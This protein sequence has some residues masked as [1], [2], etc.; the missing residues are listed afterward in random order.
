[1]AFLQMMAGCPDWLVL[2]CAVD[3]GWP[4]RLLDHAA[5][6]PAGHVAHSV[7]PGGQGSAAGAVD[8][9]VQPDHGQHRHHQLCARPHPADCAV[10]GHRR[11]ALD[12]L[13]HRGQGM[14]ISVWCAGE[15]CLCRGHGS[16][17]AALCSL[18]TR[19]AASVVH[20]LHVPGL[21]IF[22]HG[23]H[24]CQ[25]AKPMPGA[26]RN[27][28]S[29]QSVAPCRASALW[30]GRWTDLRSGAWLLCRLWAQ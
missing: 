10:L 17:G 4:A 23:P 25:S 5:D 29:Q 14:S 13:R 27:A 15:V 28:R 20:T 30:E 24:A 26:C 22:P 19:P 21:L 8:C 3:P 9:G 6:G 18:A 16:E 11:H 7:G 12:R 2:A 1:M